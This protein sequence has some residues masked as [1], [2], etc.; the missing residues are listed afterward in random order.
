MSF[1]MGFF[2]VWVLLGGLYLVWVV[3]GE[4]V[5][6]FFCCSWGVVFSLFCCYLVWDVF[7]RQNL[8]N[9]EKRNTSLVLLCR[10]DFPTDF[11]I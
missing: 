10:T 9:Q 1:G 4:C 3:G 6:V 11:S 2:L 7:I 5:L 8:C